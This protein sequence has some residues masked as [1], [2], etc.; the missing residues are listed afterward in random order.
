M[1]HCFQHREQQYPAG[2]GDPLQIPNATPAANSMARISPTRHVFVGSLSQI[3]PHPSMLQERQSGEE[4]LIETA[5]CLTPL[6]FGSRAEEPSA[7]K[8]E[9]QAQGTFQRAFLLLDYM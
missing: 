8:I 3:R 1:R 7:Q 6:A 5:K 4:A 2:G 9:A